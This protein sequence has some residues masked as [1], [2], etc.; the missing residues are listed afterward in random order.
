LHDAIVS[1]LTTRS[2]PYGVY[3]CTRN[4]RL[5]QSSFPLAVRRPWTISLAG[6]RSADAF[7]VG[8]RLIDVAAPT[9]PRVCNSPFFSRLVQ[10][11]VPAKSW[12][13]GRPRPLTRLS[14]LPAKGSLW[15]HRTL[16]TS[17]RGAS[18]VPICRRTSGVPTRGPSCAGVPCVPQPTEDNRM[19]SMNDFQ[20]ANT[21]MKLTTSLWMLSLIP[22]VAGLLCTEARSSCDSLGVLT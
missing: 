9:R 3:K 14:T 18:P 10:H 15:V 5:G 6:R 13:L 4:T 8:P 20:K 12:F 16:F 21:P 22:L 1:P 11:D 19:D 7:F 2:K 17:P